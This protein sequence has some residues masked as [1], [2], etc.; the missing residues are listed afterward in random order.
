M[1]TRDQ[2]YEELCRL[3]VAEHFSVPL[4]KV[5]STHLQGRSFPGAPALKHQIDLYVELISNHIA[6]VDIVVDAKWRTTDKVD[7]PDVEKWATVAV[8]AGAS[9]AMLITNTDF[10]AGARA[11]AEA[12]K[13][14]TAIV[15]PSEAALAVPIGPRAE[16]LAALAACHDAGA[17]LYTTTSVT[18][19]LDPPQ[20][21]P[22]GWTAPSS[23]ARVPTVGQTRVATPQTRPMTPTDTRAMPS[24][25]TTR[26]APSG[27]AG[28]QRDGSG[29]G[30]GRGGSGGGWGRGGGGWGR[31]G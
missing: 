29:H 8:S 4:D 16:V 23:E 2:W 27:P 11:V 9:K 7:Q 12:S 25:S 15:R 31:G 18:R 1:P 13:I 26:A 17:S 28:R 21:L 14:A 19:S 22:L 5:I 6:T 10:T 20:V 24:G 30:G 3:A